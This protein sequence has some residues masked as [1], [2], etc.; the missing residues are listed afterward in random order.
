MKS[1]D[2]F[3]QYFQTISEGLKSIDSAQL[4]QAAKIV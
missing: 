1:T 2:Y 4:E 3:S